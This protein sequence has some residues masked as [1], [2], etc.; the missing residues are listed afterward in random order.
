MAAGTP[1]LAYRRGSMPELIK[2]GETG[3]LLRDEDEMVAAL[4][5]V[6]AIERRR[7][8]EWVRERFSVEQMVDGY[9]K[10]YKQTVGN[11]Q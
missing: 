8:R 2:D 3:Y 4:A 10:L 7:C 5:S 1:V 11:R 9:E 6:E